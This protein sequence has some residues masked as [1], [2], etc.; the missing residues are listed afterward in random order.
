[1]KSKTFFLVIIVLVFTC[2][3]CF[4][5]DAIIINHSTDVLG[6]IPASA[7]NQAKENLHIAYGHTSHGSQLI[8]GMTGLV[9]QSSLTGYQGDIYDWNEGGTGG[10]LDIDDVFVDGD[11]GNPDRITWASRTRTYLDDSAN[12]AVNVVIWSWCGQVSS[13]TQANI[14]TYLNSMED[15]INDYPGVTFVFMTGHLDGTGTSGNLHLRNEQIRQHCQDNGRVLFD[16]ADIE[17]YDPDGNYYLDQD[18]DDNCDYDYDGDGVDDANWATDWQNS[19]TE[20]VDWYDCS[21]AHSQALNGNLKAYAAW[22][23]W[24][25]IAGWDGTDDGDDPVT[26]PTADFSASST[27]VNIN[28]QIQFTNQSTGTVTGCSWNFGDDTTSTRSNPIYAYSSAGTYNV[29]LTATN[30]GGADTETKSSYITV[31]STEDT[32]TYSNTTWYLAEGYTGGDKSFSSWILVQNPSA[33][34]ANV[35]ATFMKPG[36]STAASSFDL[37][38]QRR[39][40]ICV[41]NVDGFSNTEFSTKVQATNNVAIIAERAMYWNSGGVEWSG[42]HCSIG[43]TAPATTWYLAEGCTNGFNEYI[44]IQNPS[45]SETTVEATFMDPDGNTVITTETIPANSRRTIDVNL[46]MPDSDVSATVSSTD[47][48]GIIVE[49][50]MY[51]T[52]GDRDWVGGHCSVGVTATATSWYLA[53]GC[54]NNFYEYVCIQNPNDEAATVSATFMDQDGNTVIKTET[55]AANS[56]TTI[57]VN[58]QMANKDVSTTV[59][60]TNDVGIIAERAMYWDREG[61]SWVGGHATVGVTSSALTWYLAEGDTSSF[62]EYVLIQN[63]NSSSA[64]VMV[65]F[66][67]D[68]GSTAI[69]TQTLNPTSRQTI[70]VSSHMDGEPVSTTVESTN[71]Q[72]VIVER[73]MYWTRSGISWIGGHNTR[74]TTD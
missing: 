12:S 68:S 72:A 48:T 71:G 13:A 16:F 41:N 20:G 69:T 60:S 6:S 35:T 29:A 21:A 32:P 2:R 22:W 52:R 36:G 57:N 59:V 10:A 34:T 62:D 70:T 73:A 26:A 15:L 18:A 55:I 65:T 19:H 49:R 43:T 66:M 37:A 11:L 28:E 53:E 45:S 25:R 67:D 64:Q 74:G 40:S 54:T 33:S 44:C 51:W 23:L 5:D 3:L 61:I 38:P 42:G 31:T 4:A 9:G 8:T 17:S 1:M 56:R 24:A 47:D 39:Y 30:S 7:I 50:A 14:S 46:Q 63:P 58:S 27:T